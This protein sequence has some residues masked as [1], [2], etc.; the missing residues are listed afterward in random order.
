MSEYSLAAHTE[1]MALLH[2]R[3]ELAELY[4]A[5]TQQLEPAIQS[6]EYEQISA[7]VAAR[8]ELITSLDAAGQALEAPLNAYRA[9]RAA[10]GAADSRVA[11]AE[12]VLDQTRAIFAEVLA[13]DRANM[14]KIDRKSVV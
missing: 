14:R 6:D 2:Q 13:L 10:A 3:L 4:K 11:E 9:F 5:K 8:A 1:L 12:S 7:G